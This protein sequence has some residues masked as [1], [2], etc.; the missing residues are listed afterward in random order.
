MF[1]VNSNDK[2]QYCC[3]L[4]AILQKTLG[5]L[6]GKKEF[7]LNVVCAIHGPFWT[8]WT[9]LYVCDQR[10]LKCQPWFAMKHVP[11]LYP[12][13]GD[14]EGREYEQ[15]HSGNL[16]SVVAFR[17]HHPITATQVWFLRFEKK[18]C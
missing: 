2:E 6:S 18:H 10:G 1:K 5:F 7:V 9:D 13:P 15:C 11:A 8:F 17:W 3:F 16:H 4:K 12:S 14:L